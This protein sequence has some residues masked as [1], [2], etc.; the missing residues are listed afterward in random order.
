MPIITALSDERLQDPATRLHLSIV[1]WCL[2]YG[3]R[4]LS[5]VSFPDFVASVWRD[6]DGEVRHANGTTFVLEETDHLL[7]VANDG[8]SSLIRWLF[9]NAIQP[10][11]HELNSTYL[12]F[13]RFVELT[14]RAAGPPGWRNKL[15]D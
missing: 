13:L 7:G 9:L 8:D 11:D 15:N 3:N 5:R 2:F 14:F 1:A 4:Y 10:T 12:N 6:F